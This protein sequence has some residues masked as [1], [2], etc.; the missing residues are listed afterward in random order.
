MHVQ[1]FKEKWNSNKWLDSGVCIPFQQK[2]KGFELQGMIS[3]SQVTRKY[4]GELKENND[5][6]SKVCL[7]Q[8]NFGVN[9]SVFNGK[10]CSSLP[11]IG[12]WVTEGAWMQAP[13]S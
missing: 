9:Y 1:E 12:V 4:M 3:F 10:S 13:F 2:K 5:Y 7:M 6:F 8:S 11:G